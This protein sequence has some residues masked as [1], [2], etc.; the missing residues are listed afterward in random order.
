MLIFGGMLSSLQNDKPIEPLLRA[1]SR[2]FEL[3]LAA[4]CVISY[5]LE[6]NWERPL[7]EWRQ[8]LMLN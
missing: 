4:N 5:R 3:G 1:L 8:E 2:G 7:S 6:D